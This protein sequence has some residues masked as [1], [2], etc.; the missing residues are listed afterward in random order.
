MNK[1][2]P[3]CRTCKYFKESEN[4]S[5]EPFFDCKK[6]HMQIDGPTYQINPNQFFCSEH[7][8]PEGE[9]FVN[10]GNK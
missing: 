10:W 7:E 4:R 8:T 9:R 6:D 5:G 3:T 1:P 2:F